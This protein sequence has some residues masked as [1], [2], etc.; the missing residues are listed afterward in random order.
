MLAI[1]ELAEKIATETHAGQFRR[2]AAIPYIEH[3]R[4]VASRV[5]DDLDA[6]VLAN[7]HDVIEDCDVS[8]ETLQKGGIPEKHV[9]TVLRLT[10]S[11]GLDYA[12]YLDRAARY[13]LVTKVK[14]ANMISNLADTPNPRQI[15]KY[16]VGLERLTRERV[17]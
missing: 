9:S 12:S 7:L 2:G 10:K 5:V 13:P 3:P 11:E 15:R 17:K 16:A 6:Q 14:I 1:V 4:A 8:A